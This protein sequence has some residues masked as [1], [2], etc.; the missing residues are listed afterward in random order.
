MFLTVFVV[1]SSKGF[2]MLLLRFLLISLCLSCAGLTAGAQ[3]KVRNE[4][5]AAVDVLFPAVAGEYDHARAEELLQKAGEQGDALA[6]MWLALLYRYEPRSEIYLSWPLDAD[7]ERARELASTAFEEVSLHAEGGDVE[8]NFLVGASLFVGLLETPADANH[9]SEK[10][11]RV[12]EAE[13]HLRLAC[14]GGSA[15]A[16]EGLGALMAGIEPFERDAEVSERL[17]EKACS[18][19]SPR[20][21]ALLAFGMGHAS[22]EGMRLL[23]D[24]CRRGWGPA[25]MDLADEIEPVDLRAAAELYEE[26]CVLASS[27]SC[28]RRGMTWSDELGLPGS[29]QEDEAEE[30]RRWALERACLAKTSRGIAGCQLLGLAFEQDRNYERAWQW[31]GT[32]CQRDHESSC[33]GMK[34]MAALLRERGS[35]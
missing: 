20:A 27:W 8:A 12:I 31:Y 34:R 15:F 14:E 19:G 17:F 11:E 32:G 25:C 22:D 6:K 2:S 10:R 1:I 7:V 28:M 16:C 24:S 26:G 18:G 5:R 30:K 13:R 9:A 4:R 23:R 3:E 33:G 21:C 35:D 29:R